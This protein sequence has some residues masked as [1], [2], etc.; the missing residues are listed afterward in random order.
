[1]LEETKVIGPGEFG[2]GFV[3]HTIWFDLIDFPTSLTETTV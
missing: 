2:I 3:N 1:M